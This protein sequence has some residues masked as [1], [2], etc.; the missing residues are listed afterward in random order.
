[1]RKILLLSMLLTLGLATSG[2]NSGSPSPTPDEP[3]PPFVK[4]HPAH[5]CLLGLKPCDQIAQTP[6]GPCLIDTRHCPQAGK[7]EE[8]ALRP[9]RR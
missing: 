3:S 8:L 2:A 4:E 7:F 9:V 5:S 1:M 6:A